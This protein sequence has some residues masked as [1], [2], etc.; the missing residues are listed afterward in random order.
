MK[1][2]PMTN[3]PDFVLQKQ[4]DL[5]TF[6]H[7][8]M[9]RWLITD[10]RYNTMTSDAKIIYT[11]LLNRF[12]LSKL[13]GW[14]NESGEVFI[15]YTR[16]DLSDETKISYRKVIS[17]MRE[18]SGAKL[19][20]ER[21]CGRGDVN[22]I[23]LAKVN[24]GE[25]DSDRTS[26]PF[27]TE[28]DEAAGGA[29]EP[30][31]AETAGLNSLEIQEGVSVSADT[32]STKIAGLDL[33]NPQVKACENGTSRPAEDACQDLQNPHTSNTKKNNIDMIYT[34]RQSVG[35]PRASPCMDRRTD[36]S[37][38]LNEILD[39]CELW[40]FPAETA[41]VFESAIERLFY[42]DSF[43][44]GSAVL[45]KQKVRS[46]L[47]QLDPPRLQ[48]AEHKIAANTGRQIRNTTAYV[49]AVIFN[50]IWESESD[51]MCDPYLNSLRA[52]PDYEGRRTQCM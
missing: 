9:P 38:E 48:D 6:Y 39:S 4:T 43:K 22:Q 30:R 36:D 24:P 7:Y 49:M 21:R 41:K 2:A 37:E 46:H 14:I 8:Q 16:E 10:S 11:L 3:R 44:I 34:D 19:I 12:Q 52:P 26:V 50:S 25:G 47:H 28:D 51:L 23:Y 42:S 5:Q 1:A 27:V 15:I 31:T 13:N 29:K 40:T 45:P 32:R 33:Q 20:W 17:V 35:L 18:L